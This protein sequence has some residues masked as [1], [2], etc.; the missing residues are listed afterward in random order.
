MNSGGKSNWQDAA[1]TWR[2]RRTPRKL[3]CEICQV[4]V[5]GM[6]RLDYQFGAVCQPCEWAITKMRNAL[7]MPLGP[8]AQD[9]CAGVIPE[10]LHKTNDLDFIALAAEYFAIIADRQFPQVRRRKL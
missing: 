6:I 3:H 4:Q 10:I 1:G 8:P 2:S 9:I 5:Q 7:L